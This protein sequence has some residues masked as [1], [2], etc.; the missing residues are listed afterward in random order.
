[1]LS[2][3]TPRLLFASQKCKTFAV[4]FVSAE[5][6]RRSLIF[7]PRGGFAVVSFLFL[8]FSSNPLTLFSPCTTPACRSVGENSL[9]RRALRSLRGSSP[10]AGAIVAARRTSQ[11]LAQQRGVFA[12]TPAAPLRVAKLQDVRCAPRSCGTIAPLSRFCSAGRLRRGFFF[13][14]IFFLSLE[15]PDAVIPHRK[16]FQRGPRF[17]PHKTSVLRGPGTL[18]HRKCFRWGPLFYTPQNIRF[19]GTPDITPP[20]MLSAGTPVLYPTKH[21]FCGDPGHYPTENTFGGDPGL[22]PA[23]FFR[24][25]TRF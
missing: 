14:I 24:R 21:A 6:S 18:P 9:F 25:K 19:A 12:C 17:M 7:A 11:H 13:R 1:M 5:L 16:C 10:L 8:S 22:M 3:G 2:A 20:K 23:V 4:L 15:P